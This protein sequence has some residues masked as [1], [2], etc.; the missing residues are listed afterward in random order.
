MGF[1][2]GQAEWMRELA[3]QDWVQAIR[4]D[5]HR[6][7]MAIAQTVS[8]WAGWE[9]LE[10]RPTWVELMQR[11]GLARRSVARWLLELR[12]RGWLELLEQG[13]T[14]QTRPMALSHMEG[15]RAALYGLRLPLDPKQ[16]LIPGQRGLAAAGQESDGGRAGSEGSV[17]LNGTLPWSFRSLVERSKSGSSRATKPVDKSSRHDPDQRNNK[18]TALRAG[19]EAERIPGL[20]IMVPVSGYEMLACADDLRRQHLLFGRCSRRLVRHLCRPLWRSGWCNRDILH[21]IDYRPS[22]FGPVSGMLVAPDHIVSPT[23]FIRSRLAAW[24]TPDGAILPGWWTSRVG[25]AAAHAHSRELVRS[26][27]GRVGVRLLRAGERTLSAERIAEHG[28]AARTPDRTATAQTTTAQ[29]SRPTSRAARDRRRADLVAQARAELTCGDHRVG[30][31]S[32]SWP[33]A[34]PAG[35]T[36]YDRALARARAEG[37]SVLGRPRFR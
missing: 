1:P 25:T 18:A 14:P 10:S 23:Q 22:M 2:T 32:T 6:N 31:G 13:S 28:R 17:G 35:A 8:A 12:L 29:G 19:P 26:R 16:A 7:L 34:E 37:S 21:A 20:S 24:K 11:S 15:N 9:S 30:T 27:H 33:V 4:A 3:A 36:V 5:G